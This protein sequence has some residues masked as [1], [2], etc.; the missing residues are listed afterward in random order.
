MMQD[1]RGPNRANIGPFRLWG[2][3]HF[4]A[5]AIKMISKEDFIPGRVH[6]GLYALAPILALAPVLAAVSIIPFGPTIFPGRPLVSIDPRALRPRG[7]DRI[8]RTD[9]PT[10]A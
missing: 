5:D 2:I 3:L 1:R 6:R 9:R 4:I 10:S 7:G 8:V